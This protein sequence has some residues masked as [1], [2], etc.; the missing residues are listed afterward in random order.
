MHTRLPPSGLLKIVILPV[1]H[2]TIIGRYHWELLGES[3]MGVSSKRCWRKETG[4]HSLSTFTLYETASCAMC[5]LR[6]PIFIPSQDLFPGC[7]TFLQHV[8]VASCTSL[9]TLTL[10]VFPDKTSSSINELLHSTICSCQTSWSL[11]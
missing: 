10:L 4:D 2:L 8:L 5:I 7:Q 9:S 1:V 6:T 3:L 11:S